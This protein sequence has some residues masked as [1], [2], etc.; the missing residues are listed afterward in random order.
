MPACGTLRPPRPLRFPF[1]LFLECAVSPPDAARIW[2]GRGFWF[3]RLPTFLMH[4]RFRLSHFY[5]RNL[6]QKKKICKGPVFALN[7]LIPRAN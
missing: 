7:Q 2:T 1:C 3:E 6:S 5:R 4:T